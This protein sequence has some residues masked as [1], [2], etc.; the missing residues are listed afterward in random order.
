MQSQSEVK[1]EK[2][3][4]LLRLIDLE[5]TNNKGV[6]HRSLVLIPIILLLMSAKQTASQQQSNAKLNEAAL[7]FRRKA[8]QYDGLDPLEYMK[9][10]RESMAS[11]NGTPTDLDNNPT[12]VW[13]LL[14]QGEYSL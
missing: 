12:S 3:S 9:K 1:F 6:L 2:F 11:S 10:L 14:D 13:C 7:R 8:G 4:N 5:M